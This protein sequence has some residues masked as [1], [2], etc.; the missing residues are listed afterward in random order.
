MSNV[1]TKALVIGLGGLGCPAAL[2]LARAGVREMTFIDSDVVDVTNLH[3]QVLHGDDDLGRPKVESAA[4]KLRAAFSELKVETLRE[5]VTAQ[6]AA[7]LF[8]RHDV[9]LDC[10]DGVETKFLLSDV[11]VSTGVPLVYAGVLRLEGL[12]MRIEP[13]GPCLRCLFEAP[14]SDAPTCAQAGVL[15]TVAGVMGGLQAALA[16]TVNEVQGVAPL[17]VVDAHAFSFR[18]VNVRRRSDCAACAN[19]GFSGRQC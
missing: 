7:E 8:S 16:L 15:G 2:S 4:S 6:N 9:V 5:R 1:E 14:P 18:T 12:A 10:T 17:Q 3:R 11:S 13:G 19:A